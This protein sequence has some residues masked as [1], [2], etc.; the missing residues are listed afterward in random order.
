M[1]T[2]I[3]AVVHF[4]N[5][6][7]ATT[8]QRMINEMGDR[9]YH[10]SVEAIEFSRLHVASFDGTLFQVNLQVDDPEMGGRVP[11]IID[12]TNIYVRRWCRDNQLSL[13]DITLHNIHERPDPVNPA[14]CDHPDGS[15][16]T[17][18]APPEWDADEVPLCNRCGDVL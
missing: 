2:H 11:G 10:L 18:D 6:V 3:H 8:V 9:P 14:E 5:E 15:I 13:E 12:E 17:I 16:D 7:D 1:D 4:S